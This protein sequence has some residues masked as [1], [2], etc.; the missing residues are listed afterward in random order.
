MRR[1]ITTIAL[2]ALAAAFFAGSALGQDYTIRLSHE[3]PPSHAK[4]A[5]A[6]WFAEAVEEGSDGRI[7]VEVFPQGQLYSSEQA[8]IE[9]TIGGLIQM[10]IPSTGYVA[11][12]VPAFEVVDLPL[13]FPDQEALYAFQ[14]SAVGEE[15][16]DML[17][18]HGLVGLGY[19]SNVP[20]DMFSREPI[21]DLADFDGRRIRVHS[22]L[23]EETVRALG[24]N[25]VTIP[26]AELYLALDQGVVD[27]AFTTAAYAAPNRYYEV[28]PY[29]TRSSVSSIAYP[30]V[31]NGAFYESLP[32]DL[33]Q[34]V[35]DAVD[36][37]TDR[38]REMLAEQTAGY[39]ET[40]EE[41]GITV[42]DLND[43]QRAAWAEALQ[44][45]YGEVEGRIDPA[46]IERVRD[47]G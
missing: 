10:A 11:S 9:A 25:P 2:S 32:D 31:M 24:G 21:A 16:L 7:A 26:A 43:E 28:T 45:V 30:V 15:L 47:A 5:W 6:D 18:P 23:L 17:A 36:T 29:L 19:I 46:L 42:I 3:S 27:G 1:E 34:V 4:G 22:A 44:A 41:G 12:I 20:L 38:N 39:F 33:R 40:L 37:A 13:M 35:D 8:A 14:D